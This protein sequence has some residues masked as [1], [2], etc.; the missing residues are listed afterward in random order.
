M[1]AAAFCYV[2][3]AM[4]AT[5]LTASVGLALIGA[6]C[7]GSG[8]AGPTVLPTSAF[9][10]ETPST[11][12]TGPSGTTGVT[13]VTGVT[14]MTG[15]IGPTG[16]SGAIPPIPPGGDG[17]LTS[18][19]VSIRLSGDV[20]LEAT[21]SNLV[22][23]VASPPPGGF[24]LVWTAGDTAAT[25]VGIGGGSFTGARPTAPTLTLSI[26]AQSDTG[27]HAFVSS[28]GECSIT[29]DVAETT[30]LEGSFECTRLRSSTGEVI[31]ASG[32][33]EATG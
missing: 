11:T 9:P 33:F 26:A 27:V 13:G 14:G 12:P 7:G 25:V 5:L 18:G 17:T 32:S 8:D 21:L 20:A 19:R 31:D 4:R 1:L 10:T 23:G 30:R 16:V 3:A 2:A 15:A 28:D 24:A 6:A 22:S 29:I